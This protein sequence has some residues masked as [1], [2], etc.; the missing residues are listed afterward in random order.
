[1]ED[2]IRSRF[3]EPKTGLTRDQTTS[4]VACIGVYQMLRAPDKFGA[5]LP[6]GAAENLRLPADYRTQAYLR[7]RDG[8]WRVEVREFGL[9]VTSREVSAAVDAVAERILQTPRVL[10][11]LCERARA[12]LGTLAYLSLDDDR[13]ACDLRYG[14]RQAVD[15]GLAQRYYMLRQVI[16]FLSGVHPAQ[17]GQRELLSDLMACFDKSVM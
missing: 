10:V 12:F 3:N 6:S 11:A 2:R 9:E 17:S 7:H 4:L 1:M 15:K 5:A 8:C 16:Q 14:L 13:L